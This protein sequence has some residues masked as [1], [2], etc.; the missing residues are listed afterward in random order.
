ME[1][2][3]EHIQKLQV[4]ISKKD[5]ELERKRAELQHSN[6]CHQREHEENRE[7]RLKEKVQ[8]LEVELQR[9]RDEEELVRGA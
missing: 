7:L 9:S 6:E 4:E 2:T 5:G 1:Q 3:R 8:S